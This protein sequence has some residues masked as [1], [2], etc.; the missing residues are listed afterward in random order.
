MVMVGPFSAEHIL[1]DEHEIGHHHCDGSEEGLQALR[2][3][4]PSQVARVHG[5]EDANTCVEI[6]EA[7]LGIQRGPQFFFFSGYLVAFCS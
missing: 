6:W 3:L 1:H 7:P 5:D 2:Q 4:R